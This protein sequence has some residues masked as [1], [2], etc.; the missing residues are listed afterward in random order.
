MSEVDQ[1][2]LQEVFTLCEQRKASKESKSIEKQGGE[3]EIGLV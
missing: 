3:R 1:K 2:L